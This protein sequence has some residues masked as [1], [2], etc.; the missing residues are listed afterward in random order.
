MTI[1]WFPVDAPFVYLAS[2][3]SIYRYGHTAAV[4][5]ISAIAK[6]LVEAEIRLFCPVAHSW[7][8]I[9]AGL[10]PLDRD[11]WNKINAPFLR[12]CSVLVIAKLR[13]WE[14]SVGIA[15]EVEQFTAANKPIYDLDPETLVM[16]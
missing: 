11:R 9:Q 2:P 8:L 16:R 7:P 4:Q 3:F 14:D 5:H 1:P 12:A 15:H 6:E 13:G 10:D